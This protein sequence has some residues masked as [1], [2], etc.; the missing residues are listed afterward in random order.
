MPTGAFVLQKSFSNLFEY[1]AVSSRRYS[2]PLAA[3][4]LT[5][6]VSS[7]APGGKCKNKIA[8]SRAEHRRAQRVA[9]ER[10]RERDQTDRRMH[11]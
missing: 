5:M 10:R 3:L 6:R 11:M 9:A 7:F 2:P 4:S 1:L 8:A